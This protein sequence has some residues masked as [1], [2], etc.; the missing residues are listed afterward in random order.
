MLSPVSLF[1]TS[2]TVAYQVP[3]STEFLRQEYWSGLPFPSSGDLT[4]PRFKPR[5]PALQA[6]SLPSEPTGKP[7]NMRRMANIRIIAKKKQD[8]SK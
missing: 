3:L 6:D 5:S 8:T 1:A 7:K 4:D 2:W